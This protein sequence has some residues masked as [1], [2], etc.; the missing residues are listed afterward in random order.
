MS[1]T[2]G[3]EIIDFFRRKDTYF[4]RAFSQAGEDVIVLG[5][6]NALN[7]KKFSWIDI[8]AHHPL[9]F[10][11]TALFYKKGFRGI[12][13][14]A[15]PALIQ[16][17]YRKRPQDI[18]LN[19]LISNKSTKQKFYI[20]DPSTLSTSSKEEA[21]RLEKLGHK[22][23][24]EIEINSM[25]VSEILDKYNNGMFPDFLSIDAEGYDF[26]IIKTIKWETTNI[27]KIIC[28]ESVPYSIN[29]QNNFNYMINN[30]MTKYLLDK[31]YFIGAYT[32]IN[33]IFIQNKLCHRTF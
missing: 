20:I 31:D 16:E 29:L 24:K 32:G 14:E 18:N 21:L 30:E 12:N 10:S 5:I 8:G 11:N 26:E 25:T 3:Q 9:Y 15:D 27:P 33:T 13:I 17:F 28:I 19:V 2:T 22:I 1:F 7:L 23:K 6:I 4:K